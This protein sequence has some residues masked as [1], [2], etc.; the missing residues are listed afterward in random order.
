MDM[1]RN[2]TTIT[3]WTDALSSYTSSNNINLLFG[4]NFLGNEHASIGVVSNVLA[5][6]NKGVGAYCSPGI[7]QVAGQIGKCL[8][9]NVWKSVFP[10]ERL[11]LAQSLKLV[12]SSK[13]TYYG[14]LSGTEM[15]PLS[16]I[17][18]NLAQSSDAKIIKVESQRGKTTS[19]IRVYRANGGWTHSEN[20]QAAVRDKHSLI[21]HSA[22][23][24]TGSILAVLGLMGDWKAFSILS[25]T[26]IGNH[27]LARIISSNGISVSKH[28]ASDVNLPP[29]HGILTDGTNDLLAVVGDENAVN[30][31]V[32][33]KLEVKPKSETKLGL[34]CVA[35]QTLAVVQLG[36]LPQ[37]TFSGKVLVLLS[38][39]IGYLANVLH[40]SYDISDSISKFVTAG[41]GATHVATISANNRGAA[42]AALSVLTGAVNPDVYQSLLA[43]EPEWHKWIQ[44]LKQVV[45]TDPSQ[46]QS[47]LLATTPNR[48]TEDIEAA[49]KAVSSAI[50]TDVELKSFHKF[51]TESHKS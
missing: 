51:A 48:Y 27:Y 31:I 22:A 23:F 20:I 18:D 30:S 12:S 5:G 42:F 44:Q 26:T 46:W 29:G 9:G 19:I 28:T 32:K 43:N 45:S 39:L 47:E 34:A 24:I 6:R 36:V 8:T 11:S 7:F 35:I 13:Y 40:A 49:V 33:A 17:P 21:S 38:Y 41:S 25:L 2:W 14:L 10:G 1:S 4:A 37:A 15:K 16:N 3:Q 50:E